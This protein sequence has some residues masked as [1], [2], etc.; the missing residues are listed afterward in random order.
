MTKQTITSLILGTT[1]VLFSLI[2]G[3]D[4]AAAQNPLSPV[5]YVDD[6]VVTQ[7]EL[8]QRIE[9]L[10]VLNQPGNLEEIALEALIDDRLRRKAGAMFG[11]EITQES[12]DQGIDEFAQRANL[13]GEEM[14]TALAQEGVDSRTLHDFIEAGMI[15]RT[16]VQGRFS[17]RSQIS[18]T[19]VDRAIALAGSR[20]GVRVLLSEII[21]GIPEGREDD[22]RRLANEISRLTS[23]EEFSA[24]ARNYSAAPSRDRG[25]RIDWLPIGN[26]P[27][28]IRGK[29]LTLTP[30]QIT[31]PIDLPNAIALFQMRAMEETLAPETQTLSVDYAS[32]LIPGAGNGKAQ[33]E[34]AKLRAS[35]DTCDDLYGVAYGQAPE[36]LEREVLPLSEV[37]QNVAIELA[38]LDENE[39]STTLTRNGG[40]TLVFLML[41]GRVTEQVEDVSRDDIRLQLRN[42]RLASYADN[43]LAELRAEADIVFP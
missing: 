6:A 16:I 12:V 36:V 22:A 28:E 42:Q 24:A 14:I 11:V 1:M 34:A 10:R 21:I 33:S 37:P 32:Y 7:Y 23:A 2:S 29:V 8:A 17:A 39:V 35:V 3:V 20:G 27:P 30:G 4:R 25:G 15:W 5:V 40:D 9:F 13:T 41:C 38:K 31:E 19:E 26:L 18:D 43:Y